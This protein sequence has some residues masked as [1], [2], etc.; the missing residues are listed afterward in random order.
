MFDKKT[1]V[2]KLYAAN[3]CFVAD[4]LPI[5]SDDDGDYK[6]FMILIIV[7]IVIEGGLKVALSYFFYKN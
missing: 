3:N 6:I 1:N 4:N 7:L 5:S 2:K